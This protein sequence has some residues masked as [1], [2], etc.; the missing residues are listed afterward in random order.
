VI[1]A[2]VLSGVEQLSTPVQFPVVQWLLKV[3][4]ASAF[5]LFQH[6]SNPV[7]SAQE[8]ELKA[9][10]DTLLLMTKR[11][12]KALNKMCLNIFERYL[13]SSK[14]QKWLLEE[15]RSSSFYLVLAD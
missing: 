10:P 7:G 11:T 2:Q 3:E 4:T 1:A 5:A 14:F 12:A 15:F 8:L 9:K 6:E 13:E